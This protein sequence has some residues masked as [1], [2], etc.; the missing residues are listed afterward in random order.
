MPACNPLTPPESEVPPGM[1]RLLS[2]Q[3]VSEA[4]AQQVIPPPGSGARARGEDSGVPPDFFAEA[5]PCAQQQV[6]ELRAQL[7]AEREARLRAESYAAGVDQGWR[8]AIALLAP[9][10]GAR[11][12]QPPAAESIS[13]PVVAPVTQPASPVTLM[14]RDSPRDTPSSSVTASVT[15]LVEGGG[16]EGKAEEFPKPATLRKRLQRERDAQRDSQRDSVTADNSPLPPPPSAGKRRGA[17]RG[18]T[19]AQRDM[20]LELREHRKPES[21]PPDVRA[22]REAWN[23]LVAPHGF[24]GWGERTSVQMLDDALS[25]LARH[26]LAVWRD[27]FARVPRSPVCRGEL[28]SRMRA[29]VVWVLGRTRAGAE[30][31]EQLLS[32]AWSLD[33][34]PEAPVPEEEPGVSV[35]LEDV[36]EGTEAVRAW[37]RV[38]DVLKARRMVEA[39]KQLQSARPVTVEDGHLVVEVR[40]RFARGWAEEHYRAVLQAL[41]AAQGLVGLRF[42]VPGEEDE[43]EVPS[44]PP[45]LVSEP[46]DT[47][48]FELPP[49]QESPA[50]SLPD[51]VARVFREAKGCDYHWRGRADDDASRTLLSLAGAGGVPEILRRL[52]NGLRARFKQRCD[53]LTDLARKWNDN[54][55]PEERAAPA[56]APGR[57][58]NNNDYEEGRVDSL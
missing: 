23:T 8:Q 37:G 34:L 49:Q 48:P 1:V 45:A 51:G 9:W 56:R 31:A 14:Q 53:H 12:A 52:S 36:P 46:G 41:L 16:G 57:P 21:L 35:C 28:D 3:L 54:A 11:P 19:Q 30:V 15:Q 29:N 5:C 17:R 42:V 22:L 43:E 20:G 55:A 40:D 24:Y 27:V 18:V 38:L 47:L 33:P 58:L 26:P 6:A 2:G 10:A 25:A 4:Q 7:L 13:A 39:L 50:E 32:G 44:A